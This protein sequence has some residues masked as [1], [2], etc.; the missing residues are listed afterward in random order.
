MTTRMLDWDE[1]AAHFPPH[2]IRTEALYPADDRGLSRAVEVV[3]VVAVTDDCQDMLDRLAR[4]EEDAVDAQDWWMEW[5]G[6]KAEAIHAARVAV[7]KGRL[8]RAALD[9]LAVSRDFED[10]VLSLEALLE[11]SEKT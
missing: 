4:G 2:V 6:R 7:I 8:A 3:T 1:I 5:G 10:H 9:Q 11:E